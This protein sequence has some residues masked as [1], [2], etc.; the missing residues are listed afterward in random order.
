MNSWGTEDLK[1]VEPNEIEAHNFNNSKMA[2]NGTN[3]STE[4]GRE[5]EGAPGN[6]NRSS[7]STNTGICNTTDANTNNGSL[8][9]QSDQLSAKRSAFTQVTPPAKRKK[10]HRQLQE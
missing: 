5:E 9:L 3:G 7:P 2:T 1:T 4:V 10:K 6:T 8:T